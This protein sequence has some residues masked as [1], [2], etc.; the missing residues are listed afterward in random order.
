[1]GRD[2]LFFDR[3]EPAV[4]VNF[5]IFQIIQKFGVD[6]SIQRKHDHVNHVDI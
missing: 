3:I 5:D 2:Y 4:V 6:S 1:M